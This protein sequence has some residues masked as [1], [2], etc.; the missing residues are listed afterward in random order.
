V[1][2]LTLDNDETININST[3]GTTA[4]ANSINALASA[5]ATKIVVTG[6]RDLNLIAF[7]GSGTG[8]KTLDASAFTG[9][10]DMDVT[11]TAAASR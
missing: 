7:T 1:G 10:L 9:K 11:L 5:A 2:T 6:D 3:G 4:A 8:L